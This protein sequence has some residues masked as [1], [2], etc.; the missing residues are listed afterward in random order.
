[1]N[2]SLTRVGVGLGSAWTDAIPKV[3]IAAAAIEASAARRTRCLRLI[4]P[5]DVRRTGCVGGIT[6]VPAS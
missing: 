6:G 2:S 3:E 4:L 5:Y 1:M